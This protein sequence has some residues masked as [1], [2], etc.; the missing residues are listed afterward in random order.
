VVAH[1]LSLRYSIGELD[2]WFARW[3]EAG[4]GGIEAVH[5]S[6]RR[7][8]SRRLEALALQHGLLVSAGSDFHGENNPA[9]KLGRTSW[10]GRIPRRF[11][12]LL[13]TIKAGND[14]KAVNDIKAGND[15]NAAYREKT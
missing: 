4:V 8:E 2:G 11:S 15:I 6:A 12:E 7:A 3:K 14:I 5:P 10:G 9:R 13:Q 1:P